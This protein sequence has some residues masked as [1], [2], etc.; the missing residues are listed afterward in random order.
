MTIDACADDAVTTRLVTFRKLPSSDTL[1]LMSSSVL[2]KP[3]ESRFVQS[4]A[5]SRFVQSSAESRFVKSSAESRF[6]KSSA[7]IIND[8]AE[9]LR[10]LLVMLNHPDPP[11]TAELERLFQG[12]AGQAF[13]FIVD[14]VVGR[15]K[16]CFVRAE[17]Q[18]CVAT[19]DRRLLI[20]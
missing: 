17:L 13:T 20:S 12:R 8:G 5:E 2:S 10:A 9:R 16:T 6:A 1:A 3:A 7:K 4:S 19:M 14:H 11:S 15:Q 18:R